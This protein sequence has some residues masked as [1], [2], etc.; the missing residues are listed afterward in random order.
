[1]ETTQTQI[2]GSS[3]SRPLTRIAKDMTID[4]GL[5]C[6]LL[7]LGLLSA[8]IGR[9]RLKLIKS[10]GGKAAKL[11]GWLGFAGLIFFASPLTSNLLRT[12][13]L[14]EGARLQQVGGG[15]PSHPGPVVVLG[16]GATPDGLPGFESLERINAA[17][18]WISKNRPVTPLTVLLT[19]GP[20]SVDRP[21]SVSEADVMAR[22]L[23]M[24]MDEKKRGA[25]GRVS[26]EGGAILQ[27]L[28]ETRSLNTH[29]NAIYSREILGFT[30][31]AAPGGPG[32]PAASP[33]RIVL[34]TS[35]VHMARSAMTFAKA[36]F[37]V[38]AVVA[39]EP[40]PVLGLVTESGWLNFP[41]ARKTSAT[42][43]EW[44]GILGYWL[45][46]WL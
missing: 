45:R 14:R 21:T 23:R 42:L 24:L 40:E 8:K 11:A 20:A 2:A 26:G 22:F 44:F 36:G 18:I 4:A 30:P 7:A 43:N 19:G 6:A 32:A 37:E 39:P 9:L 31:P 33:T 28:T 13:L 3:W 38:C 12:P 27:Y 46:G 29:D 1:M 25:P 5:I 35:Q 17:S 34:V 10:N 41:T 15:C 16:G